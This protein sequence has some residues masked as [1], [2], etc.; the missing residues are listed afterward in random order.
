MA[1][2]KRG[3]G[4][5]PTGSVR[6]SQVVTSFGPGAMVDMVD[7]S[8][9]VG[10]LDFWGFGRQRIS[11]EEPRLR[12]AIARRLAKAGRSLR[13]D[14]P[15]LAPP[16][17]DDS[18]P[19]RAVGIRL[20][21][22]PRWFVC[23]NPHCRRLVRADGLDVKRDRRIHRCDTGSPTECVPVRFVG[24]CPQGHLDDWPWIFFAHDEATGGTCE[25]PQLS[26]LEGASGD[27]SEIV[28]HCTCGAFRKL[29]EALRKEANPH[30]GGIRP[31][32]GTE[33]VEPCQNNERLRLLVRTASNSYF[34]QVESALSIPSD[35]TEA[36]MSRVQQAWSVLQAATKET[37]PAF[38]QIPMVAEALH[39][40]SDA[41]VLDA[42]RAEKSGVPLERDPLRT[43]EHKQFMAQ[44]QE[45][46]GELPDEDDEF[47][48]RTVSPQGGLPLG[49]GR[50]VLAQ[51]LRE[52]R[53]EIG[54]TR[55]DFP[56]PDLQGEYDLALRTAPLGLNTDWL[57]ATEIRGEGIFLELDPDRVRE[58]ESRK[59]VLE[60]GR[61]LLAGFDAQ[62]SDV[63]SDGRPMFPGLRFYLLH[64]LSHLLSNALSLECGYAASAIRERIYCSAGDD[65]YHM[66]GILLSTGTPGTEGTLGGLVDQGR[67]IGHHLSRALELGSLC[68]NDPVCASHSPEKDLAER[69]LEGAACHGCLFIAE[70]SCER[71]N[72]Y[73]DR[74]LV[75]PVI[76]RDPALAF[77]GDA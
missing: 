52:V 57:P 49:L 23:Q 31:W 35:E 72:R 38:R 37:L 55:I 25:A 29:G 63:A 42:V 5:P 1:K 28:V 59:A 73:L 44:P 66:A 20:L 47:F 11:I 8:G 22:F 45:R 77:F 18:D 26:L 6:A 21:E 70:C 56:S 65:D 76:G 50:V 74:A 7:C 69:Y 19:T 75:V 33:G 13:K 9:L 71:F 43:A 58:W 24:A 3:G 68:S 39:T 67:Y 16:V 17:G 32:L 34:S 48:A 46:V 30:C 64:S 27:F 12:D 36:L 2:F 54:F 61:E 60:R 15:F 62:Y 4:E 40:Y 10:G 14:Q 53:V 41:E 51:K